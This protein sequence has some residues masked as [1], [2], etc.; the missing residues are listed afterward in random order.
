MTG[1]L[2]KEEIGTQNTHTGRYHVKMRAEIGAIHQK[3]KN[4]RGPADNQKLGERQK[5]K[6]K[7][8]QQ[9]KPEPFSSQKKQT[10]PTP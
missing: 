8:Q 7:K 4:T 2:M 5:N 10:M 3:P 1:V 6:N 9:K